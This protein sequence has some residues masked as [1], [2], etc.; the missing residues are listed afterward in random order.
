MRRI[1]LTLAALLAASLGWAGGGAAAS[2]AGLDELDP[3]LRLGGVAW[4]LGVAD[5]LAA[6]ARAIDHKS[7]D[8]SPGVPIATDASAASGEAEHQIKG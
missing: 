5:H 8:H 4:A 7:C 2:W 6:R 3:L 1:L